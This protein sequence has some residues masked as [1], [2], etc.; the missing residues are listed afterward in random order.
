MPSTSLADFD[1]QLLDGLAFCSGVYELFESI[2]SSTDGPSRLRRRPSR[3][4]K[5]L[6]EELMPIC[7]YVQSSYRPGRYMSIRWLDGSQQYDAELMQRGAYVSHSYYP[8]F[9]YLEVTC[10]MHKNEYLLRELL[11]TKGEAFGLEGIR[12]LPSGDIESKPISYGNREFIHSYAQVVL[13][14]VSKKAAKRYPENTTLIVECSLNMP[15]LPDEWGELMSIVQA[16]LPISK[17]REIFF[18]DPLGQYSQSFFP[19]TQ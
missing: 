15:Y 7:R 8:E 1:G 12:R 10:T 11:D 14:Q 2:R 19:R 16:A 9:G 18:Y 5:K 4:E 17:F 3:L 6:L 13:A